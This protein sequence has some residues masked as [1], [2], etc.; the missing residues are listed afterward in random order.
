MNEQDVRLQC[1]KAILQFRPDIPVDEAIAASIDA[2]KAIS[3][4]RDSH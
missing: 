3:S 4:H 2:A 1:L